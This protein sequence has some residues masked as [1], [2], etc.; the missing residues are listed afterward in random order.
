M[1]YEI[2]EL[3]AIPNYGRPLSEETC[4]FL[5]KTPVGKALKLP[6]DDIKHARRIANKIYRTAPVHGFKASARMEPGEKGVTLYLIKS[7]ASPE[8][9]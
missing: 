2:V 8:S 1:K 5:D 9:K 3:E 4:L 7:N 6:C